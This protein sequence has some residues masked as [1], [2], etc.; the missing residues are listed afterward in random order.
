MSGACTMSHQPFPYDD[1]SE[2]AVRVIDGFGLRSLHVGH[3]LDA[4]DRHA[5]L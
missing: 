2:P 3:R 4:D 5:D 1:I